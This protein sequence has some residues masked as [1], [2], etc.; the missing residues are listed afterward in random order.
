MEL[1]L[2]SWTYSLSFAIEAVA[3]LLIGV[4][5]IISVVQILRSFRSQLDGVEERDAIRL[6]LGRWLALALEFEI[7]A[8]ILRITITPTW[9]QIGQLAAVVILRTVLNFFLQSDIEKAGLKRE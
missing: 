7:A 6:R 3:A 2:K 4:A 9:N 5:V 8:D 1:W